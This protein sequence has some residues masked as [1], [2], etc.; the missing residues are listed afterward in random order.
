MP[1]LNTNTNNNAKIGTYH[2]VFRSTIHAFVIRKIS[3]DSDANKWK[4]VA[5]NLSTN[6]LIFIA[7]YI[8]QYIADFLF[9]DE[10]DLYDDSNY[11]L[12]RDYYY[13]I[14]CLTFSFYCLITLKIDIKNTIIKDKY[15]HCNKYFAIC[16]I[17]H[18]IIGAILLFFMVTYP[19]FSSYVEGGIMDDM[20]TGIESFLESIC[21]YKNFECDTF[22]FCENYFFHV[23]IISIIPLI[24]AT[25]LL[26]DEI[27]NQ[28]ALECKRRA[29]EIDEA[30]ISEV[31][32]LQLQ[33]LMADTDRDV[34]NDESNNLNNSE[35]Q[36]KYHELR[37]ELLYSVVM[38]WLI[39]VL[40]KSILHYFSYIKTDVVKNYWDD[41]YYP[42]L[43]FI[44]VIKFILK[45]IGRRIDV[46]TI[47]ILI[48]LNYTMDNGFFAMEW[49]TE[50]IMSSIYWFY[51]R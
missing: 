19:G 3:T 47:K 25:V 18:F 26:F 30:S 45:A 6:T 29:D 23:I 8:I 17:S 50:M 44:I 12:Y 38:F 24:H 5:Q 36:Q 16:I 21:N 43:I 34:D 10:R 49:I 14:I 2:H 28:T 40:I 32:E 33:P 31:I 51:F 1:S 48:S 46:A 35:N 4:F 41:Y 37:M 15:C 20:I 9:F 11:G 39:F 13:F 27:V 42:F 22:A 7:L